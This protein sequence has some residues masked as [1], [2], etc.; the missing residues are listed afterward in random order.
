MVSAG[1]LGAEDIA[2]MDPQPKYVGARFSNAQDG[3]NIYEF[4]YTDGVEFTSTAD[5]PGR[6]TLYAGVILT[7]PF[8]TGTELTDPSVLSSLHTIAEA[9]PNA[10]QTAVICGA[11]VFLMLIVGYP[12]ALLNGVIGSRY[13]EFR[14]KLHRAPPGEARTGCAASV[15]AHPAGS[16]GRASSRPR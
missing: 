2:A 7:Q 12:G 13:E 10:T 6:A 15:G 9:A 14:K 1:G 8:L 16:S 11:S 5:L 3:A 4:T